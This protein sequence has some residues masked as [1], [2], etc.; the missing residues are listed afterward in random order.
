MCEVRSTRRMNMISLVAGSER[1]AVQS[2]EPYMSSNMAWL[3]IRSGRR[4]RNMIR[5]RG[6]LGA[7][8]TSYPAARSALSKRGPL[9]GSGATSSTI[10]MGYLPSLHPQEGRAARAAIGMMRFKISTSGCS[11]ATLSAPRGPLELLGGAGG[12]W[13]VPGAIG[14]AR[15]ARPGR[16]RP[17]GRPYLYYKPPEVGAQIIDCRHD[18]ID[19]QEQGKK[20]VFEEEAGRDGEPLAQATGPDETQHRGGADVHLPAIE[21]VCEEVR[22][23]LRENPID[24]DLKAGGPGCLQGLD[25]ASAHILQHLAKELPQHTPIMD[26]QG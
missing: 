18:D 12:A 4:C 3:M 15:P 10:G 19:G 9:S 5:A 2:S 25:G 23:R 7:T 22:E 8:E 13:S 6:P 24:Q 14:T 21:G 16:P 17:P 11:S 26:P 1:T 20:L